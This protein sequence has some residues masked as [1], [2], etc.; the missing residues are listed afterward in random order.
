M[1][2]LR[3]DVGVKTDPIEYR[4]SFPWL[5]RILGDEGVRHVQLGSFFEAYWLPDR[6]YRELGV[7]A[8]HHGVQVRSLFTAHRELGGFLR[9]EEGFEAVARRAYERFIEAG[10]LLGA[11]SVGSNPGAV[12]RDQMADKP[13][14]VARYVRHMKDLMAYATRCGIDWL[15]IEPMSSLAEPPTLPEEVDAVC[16]ELADH[17]AAHPEETARAGLCVDVSHGYA[18]ANRVVRHGP[19]ELLQAAVPYLY[20]IHLKNTDP[21]FESTFGFSRDERVRGIVDLST[22]RDL[23]LASADRLPVDDVVGYLEIGGPKLGRDYTDPLLERALRESI[24][25][26]RDT[27]RVGDGIPFDPAPMRARDTGV[28][29]APSVMC[30]DLCR[31]EHSVQQLEAAGADLLHFDVMDARFTPNMPVGLTLMEQ[32]RDR[33]T[34][35]FDIHLMVHDNDWFVRRVAALKPHM[36]SVHAESS[37]HL[38]RTLDLIRQTGALAGAALNPGTPLGVLEYVTDKLDFVLLMTVNPGFAG[39]ALIPAA[40]RKIADCRRFLDER[41]PGIP[42]Q[43]DGNV[44]FANIPRMV[45]LGAGILVAGSSSVFH[46]SGSVPANMRRVLDLLA[47]APA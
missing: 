8:E 21:H 31:L 9:H 44:S 25:H 7:I 2:S 38:D 40:L 47:G 10:A 41:R 4:Y 42:I 12:L 5:F 23:L 26:C 1:P 11:R 19:M 32:L 37:L 28:R 39:Q 18:D 36:V 16:R 43:V 15:T 14:A 33:T 13:A 3:L 45:E 29:I 6:F 20:E 34:M 22:V 35:P 46:P 30:A 27:F 24:G 17:H